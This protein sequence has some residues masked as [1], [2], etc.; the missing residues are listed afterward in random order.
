MSS[1]DKYRLKSRWAGKYP[2]RI[3]V[4]FERWARKQ[5]KIVFSEEFLEE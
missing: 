1:K 2:F 4:K 5:I 3:V